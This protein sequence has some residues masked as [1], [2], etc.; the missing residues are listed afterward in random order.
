[1][2]NGYAKTNL[3]FVSR[4]RFPHKIFLSNEPISLK[5]TRDQNSKFHSNN[6]RIQLRTK[7]VRLKILLAVSIHHIILTNHMIFLPILTNASEHLSSSYND[8]QHLFQTLHCVYHCCDINI[9]FAL[10]IN[11]FKPRIYINIYNTTTEYKISKKKAQDR[12]KY[13]SQ[14]TIWRHYF[15][16]EYNQNHLH[17]C[18]LSNSFMSYSGIDMTDSKHPEQDYKSNNV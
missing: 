1:M 14:N 7:T 2:Y 4:L 15:T 13:N 18:F 5:R 12:G 11:N 8:E 3:L 16:K 17:S 9:N 6:K 10:I